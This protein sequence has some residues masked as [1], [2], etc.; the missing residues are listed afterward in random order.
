MQDSSVCCPENTNQ[1]RAAKAWNLAKQQHTPLSCTSSTTPSKYKHNSP[2]GSRNNKNMKLFFL[3][4]TAI[5]LATNMAMTKMKRN[6]N[7]VYEDNQKCTSI[8]VGKTA[9]ADGSTVTTHNNDC[10]E[11]DIRITHVP[12]MDWPAG[13]LRPI[14]D[15]RDHYPR[16]FEDPGS[17]LNVHGPDYD[18]IKVDTSI[19]N[20]TYIQP[21][22]FIDQIPHTYAYT[23][24]TYAIQNEK[25]V[26]IGES[27]CR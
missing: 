25:Q 11:C 17:E 18:P 21:M 4:I 9:M 1:N 8:G 6:N 12:A 14:H 16:Y 10:K 13:S 24:G 19:Y 3:C 27:T 26:S 15:I 5:S 22:G 20:W 7:K 2:T 23:L